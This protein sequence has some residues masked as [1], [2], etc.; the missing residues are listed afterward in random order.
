M[1]LPSYQL[2]A[3][4][5]QILS[6]IDYLETELKMMH[7]DIKDDNIGLV[8]DPATGEYDYRHIKVL[9]FGNSFKL[10]KPCLKGQAFSF[11]SPEAFFG[12]SDE[13][14]KGLVP[15]SDVWSVGVMLMQLSAS[16]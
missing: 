16:R 13:E 2:R 14:S 8:I 11:K 5:K 15:K 4:V 9:D 12:I 10:A 1:G 6:F 3:I 7:C